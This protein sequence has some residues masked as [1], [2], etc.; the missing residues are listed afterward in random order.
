MVGRKVCKV[1]VVGDDL[2]G[3]WRAFQERVLFLKGIDDC[4]KFFLID[5]IVDFCWGMLP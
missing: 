5:L 1:S 4:E 3:M 2:N